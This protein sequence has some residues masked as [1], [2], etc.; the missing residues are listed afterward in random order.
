MGMKGI[1]K[2]AVHKIYGR[3]Q[4]FSFAGIAKN[5]AKFEIVKKVFLVLQLY[6]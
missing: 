4:K 5:L 1:K 2:Q 3:E 6:T